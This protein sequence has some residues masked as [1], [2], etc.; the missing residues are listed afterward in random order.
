MM[1]LVSTGPIQEGILASQLNILHLF[2]YLGRPQPPLDH[3]RTQ[4]GSQVGAV[5]PNSSMDEISHTSHQELPGRVCKHTLRSEWEGQEGLAAQAQVS[6]EEGQAPAERE[7]GCEGHGSVGGPCIPG[8]VKCS[9]WGGE[10]LQG[11]GGPPHQRSAE[12]G[13]PGWNQGVICHRLCHRCG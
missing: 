4:W 3:L 9:S 7:Q 12:Q 8:R 5:T 11:W 1:S 6:L 10:A 2:T 13:S